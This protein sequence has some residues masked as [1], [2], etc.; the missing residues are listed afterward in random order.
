MV[1]TLAYA[2]RTG[3]NYLY[4]T[5]CKVEDGM[6]MKLPYA[7]AFFACWLASW[8]FPAWLAVGAERAGPYAL[9]WILAALE[10]SV[11]ELDSS[12]GFLTPTF[13]LNVQISLVVIPLL[14]GIAFGG[15]LSGLLV[16]PL[17]FVV[18]HSASMAGRELLMKLYHELQ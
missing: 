16:T 18:L 8:M 4:V 17:L 15:D 14:A 1:K 9:V 2:R 12:A 11:R 13:D 10:C 7:I 6:A 5:A 3:Q